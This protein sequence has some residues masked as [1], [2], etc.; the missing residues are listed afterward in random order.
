MGLLKGDRVEV[1]IPGCIF[2]FKV[3]NTKH[4]IWIKLIHF[5]FQVYGSQRKAVI[6]NLNAN[7]NQLFSLIQ[8]LYYIS[9]P[10]NDRL[11]LNSTFITQNH[12]EFSEDKVLLYNQWASD[13]VVRQLLVLQQKEDENHMAN[14]IITNDTE[15]AAIP[16][17]L[18]RERLTNLTSVP[19]VTV[20]MTSHALRNLQHSKYHIH[21]KTMEIITYNVDLLQM[22]SL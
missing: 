22:I 19:V 10:K 7:T 13:S 1:T 14:E 21:F 18:V 11:K 3:V 20:V 15:R 6:E 9:M 8:T 4:R 12:Q 16:D 5:R 2:V 17:D